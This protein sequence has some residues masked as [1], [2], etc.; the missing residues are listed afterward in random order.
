MKEN[1]KC[2]YSYKFFNEDRA[3]NPPRE[4]QMKLI[5]PSYAPGAQIVINYLISSARLF[6]Y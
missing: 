6:P 2:A 3:I 4:W 1:I 5:L